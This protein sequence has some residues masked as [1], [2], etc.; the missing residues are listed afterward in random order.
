MNHTA[1]VIPAEKH[2]AAAAHLPQP[3]TGKLIVW[4]VTDGSAGTMAQV[5]ALSGALGYEAAQKKVLVRK[6]LVL[7]PNSMFGKSLQRMIS[8][9]LESFDDLSPP[10]PDVVISCGRRGAL[11]A[12]GIKARIGRQKNTHFIHIHD[13]QMDAKNFDV[14]VA[15]QHDKIE[16]KNV[17]KS[18]FSLHDITEETLAS[19]KEKFAKRFTS[20]PKPYVAV[21]L[22]GSTNK[23]RLGAARMDEVISTLRRAQ[24][25]TRGSLLITPSRR[26]GFANQQMLLETFPRVRDS[27]VYVYD[28]ISENPYLGM[29]ALAE[30]ILVTNDSVNMMSEAI[31]S[32]KPVYILRLPGHQNT[33][34]ARFAEK[35]IADGAARAFDG[36]FTRWDHPKNDE[37]QRIAGEIKQRLSL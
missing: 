18:Q 4:G 17:I 22:G 16:A 14:V 36:E 1:I 15:M 12:L 8:P 10:W 34:P 31:A 7:L 19:A 28:G 30:H 11:A 37:M 35:L 13:P 24:G 20:Y 3:K 5:K 32:G 21:L 33:K 27:Q 25:A 26:T 9:F 6:P 2:E 23:Y 29:L